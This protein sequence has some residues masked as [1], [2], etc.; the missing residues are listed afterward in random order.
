VQGF[1]IN[2]NLGGKNDNGWRTTGGI[3]GHK[4]FTVELPE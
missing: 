2:P 3:G 1:A 4:K